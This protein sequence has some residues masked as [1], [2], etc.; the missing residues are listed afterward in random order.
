MAIRT[1]NKNKKKI[2]SKDEQLELYTRMVHALVGW[3]R[4]LALDS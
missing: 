1:K 2:E 4:P 3:Q